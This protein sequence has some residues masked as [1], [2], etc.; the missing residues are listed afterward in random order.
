ME[1]IFTYSNKSISVS[2]KGFLYIEV[3]VIAEIPSDQKEASSPQTQ[4]SPISHLILL[5]AIKLLIVIL[6]G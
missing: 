3:I 4:I 1:S 6:T 5:F 2:A